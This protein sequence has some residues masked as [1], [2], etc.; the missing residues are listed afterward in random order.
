MMVGESI[1]GHAG[2]RISKNT[3]QYLLLALLVG[4]V[5]DKMPFCPP[6]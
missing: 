4:T 1:E 5:T 2:D 6:A 3:V